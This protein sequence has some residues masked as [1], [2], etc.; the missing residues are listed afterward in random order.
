MFNLI[1]LDKVNYTSRALKKLSH[2][3]IT[4]STDIKYQFDRSI[5][6]Y[7]HIIATTFEC[8]SHKK[9]NSFL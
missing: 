1:F 2:Y 6:K 4:L 8:T 7:Q 9:R 5:T 3:N